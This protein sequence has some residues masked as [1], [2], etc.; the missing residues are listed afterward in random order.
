ME[1]EELRTVCGVLMARTA[2]AR[3]ENTT[4]EELIEE[5]KSKY[6]YIGCDGIATVLTMFCRKKMETERI[7]KTF[8]KYS[9]SLA[10]R[11]VIIWVSLVHFSTSTG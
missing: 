1:C 2:L 8:S 11:Q 9:Q 6:N 7:K 5:I 4:K 10:V 3:A